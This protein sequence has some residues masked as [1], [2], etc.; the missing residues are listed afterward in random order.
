MVQDKTEEQLLSVI[1]PT[2]NEEK[3]IEKT[4]NSVFNTDD[5]I[6]VIVVDGGSQDRTIELASKF[7]VVV[8]INSKPGRATQQNLAA[9]Q[10]KG[11]VLLFLHADSTLPDNYAKI[12]R[13]T[14]TQEDVAAGAFRF[15]LDSR[16][17]KMRCLEKLVNLRS[18]LFGLPYGDQGIFIKKSNFDLIHGFPVLQIMEDYLF[19]KRVKALGRVVLTKGSVVTSARRWHKLGLIKTTLINQ[20]VI[21]GYHLGISSEK[22]GEWYHLP[23]SDSEK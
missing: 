12:I 7:K 6:E 19:I 8:L 23:M 18:S 15:S 17:F 4:L 13:Q 3:N 11:A 22:L 21:L 20:K 2:Y 14:L 10:A 1:I 5:K 16:L 9:S